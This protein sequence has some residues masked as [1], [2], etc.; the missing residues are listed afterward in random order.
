MKAILEIELPE[1]CSECNLRVG[2]IVGC[3]YCA[4]TMNSDV[5]NYTKSRSPHCPLKTIDEAKDSSLTP[6]GE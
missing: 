2:G 1:S 4:P 3:Y 5:D 6:M